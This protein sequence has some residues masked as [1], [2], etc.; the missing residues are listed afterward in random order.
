MWAGATPSAHGL[1]SHGTDWVPVLRS[2][3]DTTTGLP[4]HALL[5]QALMAFTIDYEER[6]RFPMS[7]AAVSQAMP[8]A[9]LP[10]DE[11]PRILGVNGTGKSLLERHGVVR[12]T[13]DR[14]QRI[15]NLTPRGVL[16]RDSFEPTLAA[17]ARAWTEHYGPAVVDD[18]HASLEQVDARLPGDLPDHLLV[19][20]VPGVGFHDVSE[21]A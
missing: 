4:V 16:V 10:L 20:F 14:K 15:A 5:S 13:G 3:G 12:V 8:G 7:I 2:D 9:T 21:V 1:P 17:V 6:A 11:V 18:L 19:R